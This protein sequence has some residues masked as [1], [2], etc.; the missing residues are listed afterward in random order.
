MSENDTPGMNDETRPIES[1]SGQFPAPV[2]A[3]PGPATPAETPA[4]GRNTRTILEIVGGV[5]AAGLIVVAGLVGFAVGHWTGDDR[6]GRRGDSD[7]YAMPAPGQPGQPGQPG[8][9]QP[10]SGQRGPGMGHDGDR[11]GRGGHDGYEDDGYEDDDYGQQGQ[12]GMGQQDQPGLGF[13]S[14][15]P[16]TPAPTS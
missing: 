3:T 5:V 9:G 15:S 13:G 8:M 11:S 4:K 14:P 6:D 16:T 1:A 10:G 2:A 7:G 12:P